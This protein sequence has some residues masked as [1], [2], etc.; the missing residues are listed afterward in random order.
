MHLMESEDQPMR[1]IASNGF[2]SAH[3]ILNYRYLT[4]VRFDVLLDRMTN[5][6]I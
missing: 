3:E 1:N 2:L 6:S 5:L 4:T